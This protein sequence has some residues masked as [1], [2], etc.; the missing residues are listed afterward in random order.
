MALVHGHALFPLL[1]VMHFAL[2]H[3]IADQGCHDDLK[4][5]LCLSMI[6]A[7]QPMLHMATSQVTVSSIHQRT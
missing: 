2:S 6:Q 5:L 1:Q 7:Q 4:L 3:R